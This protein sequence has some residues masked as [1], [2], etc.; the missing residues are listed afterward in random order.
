M[1]AAKKSPLGDP[2]VTKGPLPVAGSPGG[3]ATEYPL[4]TL[5]RIALGP[6][7]CCVRPVPAGYQPG[8]FPTNPPGGK[9]KWKIWGPPGKNPCRGPKACV[10]AWTFLENPI[11][12]PKLRPDRQPRIGRWRGFFPALNRERISPAMDAAVLNLTSLLGR[13]Q[14]ADLAADYHALFV[15]PFAP[16]PVELCLSHTGTAAFMVPAWPRSEVCLP[17]LAW[18]FRQTAP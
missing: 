14:S 4:E 6:C 8:F 13:V 16:R 3:N 7:P 11:F 1:G 18:T 5:G 17:G 2:G 10:I 15:D 12:V 9:P